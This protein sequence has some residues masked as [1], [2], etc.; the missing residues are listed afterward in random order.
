MTDRYRVTG[1]RPAIS[2]GPRP[3]GE[4]YTLALTTDDGGRVEISLDE[5]AM[6]ELWVEVRGV[7]WPSPRRTTETDRMIRQLV[8][9]ANGAD[10]E[11]LR[12]ALDAMGVGD[13]GSR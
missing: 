11:M 9:R 12:R 4:G 6:Y 13:A 3:R 8:H 1:D 7:P 10:E 5:R 2:Y